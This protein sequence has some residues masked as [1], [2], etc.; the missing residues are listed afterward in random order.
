[1]RPPRDVAPWARQAGD[2]AAPNRIGN[3]PDDDGDCRGGVLG[4]E[5]RGRGRGEDEVHL[6]AHELSRELGELIALPFGV[7]DLNRDVLALDP[8][9]LA[10]S[11]SECLQEGR[12]R[13]GRSEF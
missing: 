5:G 6:A 3:K 13:G 1:M 9:E 10:E 2:D 12:T 11:L 8:A 7:A 4:S